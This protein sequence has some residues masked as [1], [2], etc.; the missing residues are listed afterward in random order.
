MNENNI[1]D[2][3]IREEEASINLFDIF[4]LILDKWYWFVLSVTVCLSIAVLY[5]MSTPKIYERTAVVLVKDYR[6]N[7]TET[8]MFQ[9]LAV[10]D[11]MSNVNNEV[12]ILKSYN[13]M[14]EAV[15]R[16]KLDISYKI[17][18]SREK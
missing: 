13:I 6:T 4:R 2:N 5:L 1:N 12:I 3:Q 15:R 18:E 10:Y 9:E 17:K 7:P 14:N 8:L 16:L 11:G